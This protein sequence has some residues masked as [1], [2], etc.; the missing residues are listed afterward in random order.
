MAKET[1][2]AVRRSNEKTGRVRRS[3]NLTP[4]RDAQL[5]RLMN[6]HGTIIAVFEAGM[7]SL[8]RQGDLT[9]ADVKAWLDRNVSD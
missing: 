1:T 3:V 8:E 4:E 6:D 9:K 7:D 2:K 5:Q